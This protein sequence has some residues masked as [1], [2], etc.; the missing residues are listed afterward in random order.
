MEGLRIPQDGRLDFIRPDLL[1]PAHRSLETSA[2][3]NQ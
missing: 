3:P 2:I 1:F